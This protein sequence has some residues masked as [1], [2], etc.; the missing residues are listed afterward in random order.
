[1]AHWQKQPARPQSSVKSASMSSGNNGTQAQVNLSSSTA[2]VGGHINVA[3]PDGLIQVRR[4]GS[5]G[6]STPAFIPNMLGRRPILQSKVDQRLDDL[7]GISISNKDT[8]P[9]L[10]TPTRQQISRAGQ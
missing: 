9:K 10:E 8:P 4:Y 6:L 3:C 1:M 7:L 5:D 2:A